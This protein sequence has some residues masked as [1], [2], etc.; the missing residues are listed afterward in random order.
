MAVLASCDAC[1]RRLDLGLA[2]VRQPGA[3]G[4]VGGDGGQA[5]LDVATMRFQVHLGE[6]VQECPLGCG[7]IPAGFKVVAEALGLVAGPRLR[8][9]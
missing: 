5:P 9:A 4:A 2:Q 3:S 7:K 1:E 8:R 6:R